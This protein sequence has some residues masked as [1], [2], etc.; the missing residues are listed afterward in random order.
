MCRESGNEYEKVEKMNGLRTIVS[1]R[2]V[3]SVTQSQ[4]PFS[5]TAMCCRKN[6]KKKR[7]KR[8]KNFNTSVF[9]FLIE[10]ECTFVLRAH[11]SFDM[12][13]DEIPE[14]IFFRLKM[15]TYPNS[16]PNPKATRMES[17]SNAKYK[18]LVWAKCTRLK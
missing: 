10:V 5:I 12:V 17:K 2:D 15:Y 8:I 3:N 16:K 14:P 7:K 18:M 13:G 4:A 9:L 11:Y 6:K 1:K